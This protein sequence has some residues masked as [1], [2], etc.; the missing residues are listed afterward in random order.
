MRLGF[1]ASHGGSN[2][3][4]ILD[5]C[6]IGS[7]KAIPALL[8]CNNRT[9]GAIERSQKAN[10]PFAVLN[11]KTHPD[12]DALDQAILNSLKDAQVELVVLAGYMKK[13]GPR[14][15][16]AYHNRILNIHPALLPKF[17]GQGMYGMNVHK[18]VIA[19]KETKSGATVHLIDEVYD[20]GPILQQVE[21]PVLPEDTPEILQAR[22]LTQEHFLYPDT[23]AKIASGEIKLP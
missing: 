16:K 21:V 19:A 1:L 22:V 14:V 10:M 17:G 13:I 8:V 7:I 12:E 3:Q 2:M 5:A 18:A 11:G 4:A 15:L 20:E 23:I 9:A 6:A